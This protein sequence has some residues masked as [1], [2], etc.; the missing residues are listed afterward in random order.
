MNRDSLYPRERE[1]QAEGA[2]INSDDVEETRPLAELF[3]TDCSGEDNDEEEE[4]VDQEQ[5]EGRTRPFPGLSQSASLEG[6]SS[7]V[8]ALAQRQASGVTRGQRGRADGEE[9]PGHRRVYS[10]TSV[11]GGESSISRTPLRSIATTLDHALELMERGYVRAAP[12]ALAPSMWEADGAT[13][14]CRGCD[15]KFNV[16]VRRHHCRRCGLV[17]CGS[18]TRHRALLA[19]RGTGGMHQGGGMTFQRVCE[20][21][22]EAL[23]QITP[24][25]SPS[26]T[27]PCT[28]EARRILEGGGG[29]RGSQSSEMSECPVCLL[30]LDT[31]QTSAERERHVSRCLEGGDRAE[32]EEDEP[33]RPNPRTSAPS[34]GGVRYAAYSLTRTS[35]LIGQECLICFEDFA[36]DDPV[37]C[38]NCMCHFHRACVDAW[39]VRGRGCPVHAL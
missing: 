6:R 25:D 31:L 3:T 23:G 36:P 8:R 19:A 10:A 38:L 18:C 12:L 13:R 24:L 15:R 37:A 27:D 30:I 14:A 11:S 35:T 17:F 5:E 16:W 26:P 7:L 20:G 22:Y 28:T 9:G 32:D 29:R 33:V 34:L 1:I 2:S 4:E 21:C 39:L